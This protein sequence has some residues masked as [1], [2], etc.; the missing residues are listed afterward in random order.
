MTNRLA[1]HYSWLTA[2]GP[3]ALLVTILIIAGSVFFSCPA[4]AAEPPADEAKSADAI[5]EAYI[6]ATGGKSAYDQIRNRIVDVSL[7]IDGTGITMN[8]TVTSARPNLSHTLFESDMIGR[9]EKGTDG[10]TVWANST[11]TGP[12]IV[13]G[14]EREFALRE[15]ALDK[16]VHWKKLY[17][18]AKAAGI[19]ECDGRPC[20]KVQLTPKTGK[21]QALYFDTQSSLLVRLD[22]TVDT[23]MGSVPVETVISDYREVEGILLPHT[24][25]V[26]AAGQVRTITTTS[27]RHNVELPADLF[28]PP[29]E[30]LA[31]MEPEAE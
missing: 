23:G 4:P 7:E 28:G 22:M 3:S 29:A 27:V 6:E 14:A 5:L 8:G 10:K 11:M 26:I 13:E 19:E 2:F 12:Q 20:H 18:S 30:V 15:G 21:P 24:V 25:K 1:T 16:F 17:A 31:L 9:V